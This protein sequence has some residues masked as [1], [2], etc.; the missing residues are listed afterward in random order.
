[1]GVQELRQLTPSDV[2]AR[3]LSPSDAEALINNLRE[4]LSSQDGVCDSVA[5]RT[6]SKHV[7]HP[8]MPFEV[9]E[10]LYATCYSG[11]DAAARGPPPMWVPEPTGMKSTNAARF[12]ENWEGPETWQRLRSGDASKDYALLQRL[13]ATFPESF[14]PAVFARLRVRFEQAPSAVLT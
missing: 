1:M 2:E 7:L 3:K 14:W 11:W 13:S 9:H 12:M 10:L 6:V 8:D 4:A 5:W